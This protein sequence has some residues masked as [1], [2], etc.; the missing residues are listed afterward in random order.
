MKVAEPTMDWADD[1]VTRTSP[2]TDTYRSEPTPSSPYAASLGEPRAYVPGPGRPSMKT[3]SKLL[4]VAS[5]EIV[6]PNV[7][8]S[9]KASVPE[10]AGPENDRLRFPET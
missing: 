6:T 7:G 10:T 1:E 2:T 8:T 4:P 9:V 5:S 3:T